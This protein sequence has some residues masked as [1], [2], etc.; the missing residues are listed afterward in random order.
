M[1]IIISRVFFVVVIYLPSLTRE[2][3]FSG[4]FL[5]CVF[6]QQNSR[7]VFDQKRKKNQR[8]VSY[9]QFV[10]FLFRTCYDFKKATRVASSTGDNRNFHIKIPTS[11]ELW[12]DQC[13]PISL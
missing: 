2:V 5:Y 10:C 11:Q 1:L 6:Y 13:L 3:K 7:E 4:I 9:F 8:E 12:S